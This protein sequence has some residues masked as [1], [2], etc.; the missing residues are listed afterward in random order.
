MGKRGLIALLAIASIVIVDG[1]IGALEE[2]NPIEEF[3]VDSAAIDY[4]KFLTVLLEDNEFW[5]EKGRI[6]VISTIKS[7]F[8]YN[9]QNPELESTV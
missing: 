2:E 8:P 7:D 4:G 5:T 9:L 1:A 3:D 6:L